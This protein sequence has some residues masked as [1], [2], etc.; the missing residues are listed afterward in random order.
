MVTSPRQRRMISRTSCFALILM[1]SALGRVDGQVTASLTAVGAAN[2][3]GQLVSATVLARC[4]ATIDG[5]SFGLAHDPTLLTIVTANLG[6]VFATTAPDF[7]DMSTT[8]IGGTGLTVGMLISFSLTNGLAPNMDHEV[9]QISYLIDRN[10]PAPAITPLTFDSNLGSPAV[11]NLV[12]SALIEVPPSLT[13]GSIEFLGPDCNNNLV[14][15]SSDLALGTSLDCNLSGVPDECEILDGTET[16]CNGDG[17]LDTCDADCDLDGSSD[18]CQILID[19][20][21]DC[22]GNG[23]P[24]SCD[25]VSGAPDCDGNAVLDSCDLGVLGADQNSDGRLDVCEVQYRRGDSN[26]TGE[27]N[28]ADPYLILQQLFVNPNSTN[29]L[30]ACDTNAD[31]IVDLTDAVHSLEYLFAGGAA[32]IEP[33]VACGIDPIGCTLPCTVQATCP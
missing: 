5:V 27:I 4:S 26:G 9:V 13:G 14:V 16:D 25:L 10:A 32:L 20:A 19:P 31:C 30:A 11:A 21:I 2:F 6:S 7:I 23:L 18:I 17:V 24:D 29:C 15:D 33:F 8:T 12:V 3:P 22:D 28:L 1:V